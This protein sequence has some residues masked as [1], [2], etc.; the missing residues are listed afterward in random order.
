[1]SLTVAMEWGA[2]DGYEAA[3]AGRPRTSLPRINEFD[4]SEE[5]SAYTSLFQERY[6][7]TMAAKKSAGSSDPAKVALAISDLLAK[8]AAALEMLTD[9]PSWDIADKVASNFNSDE[10]AFERAVGQNQQ[11]LLPK[12]DLVTLITK[13]V[14]EWNTVYY[15][16]KAR[17]GYTPTSAV[18]EVRRARAAM[19]MLIGKVNTAIEE[20]RKTTPTP[21]VPVKTP[22]APP[23]PIAAKSKLPAWAIVA[24]IVAAA[25]GAFLVFRNKKKSP[26]ML[27]APKR[28]TF[29][30]AG[31]PGTVRTGGW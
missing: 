15:A 24:A 31:A 8:D 13:F 12:P 20:S 17:T 19:N 26:P 22:A 21:A 1:M 6:D 3:M 11:A 5:K 30:P 7:Q 16:I 18:A 10:K 27:N 23:V 2:Q 25:G 28:Y 14:A 29:E 9:V 4:T